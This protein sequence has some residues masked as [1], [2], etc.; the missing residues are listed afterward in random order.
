MPYSR[1]AY[2]EDTVLVEA[3]CSDGHGWW[4]D[5]GKKDGYSRCSYHVWR[6]GEVRECRKQVMMAVVGKMES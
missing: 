3:E 2:I 4:V 5:P 1:P 6:N